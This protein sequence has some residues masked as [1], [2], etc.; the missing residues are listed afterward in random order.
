M[1]RAVDEGVLL[2]ICIAAGLML[3]AGS[4]D[5]QCKGLGFFDLQ[6]KPRNLRPRHHYSILCPELHLLVSTGDTERAAR[7]A[8]RNS[9]FCVVESLK[10]QDDLV[11]RDSENLPT[12]AKGMPHEMKV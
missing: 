4:M 2:L 9:V 5:G 6:V 10:S 7:R 12:E 1:R 3:P 11:Y 8:D